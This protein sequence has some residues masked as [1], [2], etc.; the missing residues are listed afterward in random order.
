MIVVFL[1]GYAS[2]ATEHSLKVNKA[3]SALLLCAI[4]WTI[5]VMNAEPILLA[6]ESFMEHF[7]LSNLGA[8]AA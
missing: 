5:Y 1:I 2:I 6:S 3:A 4:L 7:K 8:A